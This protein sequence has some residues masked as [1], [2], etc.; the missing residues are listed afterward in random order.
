MLHD[1]KNAKELGFFSLVSHNGNTFKEGVN[2]YT[3]LGFRVLKNY[4]RLANTLLF[5]E[6]ENASLQRGISNDSFQEIWLESF[7][8]QNQDEQG[9]SVP[10]Q[11][12]SVY[13]GDDSEKL[14]DG[15]L[16]KLRLVE[17]EQLKHRKMELNFF[18]TDLPRVKR[19]LCDDM[20]LRIDET[21]DG[22]IQV[23]DPFGS[24]LTFA[25]TENILWL[26]YVCCV[27]RIP[28]IS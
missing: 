28:R 17:T 11:E 3:K 4:S 5:S 19:I 27:R 15:L 14:S 24:R 8:L 13:Q 2:F 7:S 25:N 22:C 23:Q 10:W 1:G 26:R 6:S 12:L 18:T 16:L 21:A 9:N 20:K